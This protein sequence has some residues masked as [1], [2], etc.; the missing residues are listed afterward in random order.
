MTRNAQRSRRTAAIAATPQA[1]TSET[2]SADL[3]AAG[4]GWQRTLD[5][6][7][8]MLG[9]SLESSRDWMQGLG[10]WQQAQAAALRHAGQCIEQIAEQ[11]KR[12]PDWPAL[13]ASLAKLAGTQ[14]TQAMDDGSA[15]AEQAMQIES[16]L[17]ERGRTDATRLS[18][19]WMGDAGAG[20]VR[21]RPDA[22]ELS[23]PL[24]LIGQAQAAMSEMSRLWTQALYD[25]TLPD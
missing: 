7:R 14:W 15:L 13:W 18:Q 11:T 24:V 25:T 23:A 2:S 8:A 10:D 17:V 3:A 6:T 20:A 21:D 12:A 16:R 4:D 19:R 9:V 22:V 1:G 5:M